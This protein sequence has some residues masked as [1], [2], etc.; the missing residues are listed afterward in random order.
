MPPAPPLSLKEDLLL[1]A[2]DDF[3]TSL[4]LSLP[5]WLSSPPRV[6]L[7][8]KY[9]CAQKIRLLHEKRGHLYFGEN[10][11]DALQEKSALLQDTAIQWVYVGALQSKQIKKLVSIGCEIQ[12]IASLKHLTIL[13]KS[14]LPSSYFPHTKP[15]IFLQVNI[16]RDRQKSGFSP[17]ECRN[18]LRDLRGRNLPYNLKGLMALFSQKDSLLAAQ[19]PADPPASYHKLFHLFRDCGLPEL[20]CGMSLDWRAALQVGATTLRI[21]KAVFCLPEP[22]A[23]PT[24]S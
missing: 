9:V 5:P 16:S 7:I 3:F 6:V 2:Y 12:T 13:E 17:E 14:I 18:L 8:S 4:S 22:Q 11:L 1:Q 21:G 20:S 24:V 23:G 19:N 10:R 15:D